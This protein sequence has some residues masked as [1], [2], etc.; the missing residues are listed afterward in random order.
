MAEAPEIC[1]GCGQ[2]VADEARLIR[3]N[4]MLTKRYAYVAYD[5][6][7]TPDTDAATIP[8][9]YYLCEKCGLDSS[10][11]ALKADHLT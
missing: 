5:F 1:R 6:K 3:G 2:S 11:P 4:G 7:I 8:V 10:R 9:D